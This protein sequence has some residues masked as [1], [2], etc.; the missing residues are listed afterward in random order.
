MSA[1]HP[2]LASF[3]PTLARWFAERL[4]A[5]SDPQ[6]QGWPAI[7]RGEHT[8]IAAPTGTGKTLAAFLS[9][10][11]RLLTSGQALED[12]CTLLY[13]SPLKAL[14][15]DVQKNLSGPL[16][17]LRELDPSLPEVRVFVRSGDTPAAEREKM[18]RRPPHVVVTTPESFY[19]LLTSA[20]GRRVL[21]T[22]ETVIIDEIHAI[23]GDKRGAHLA[24][25][26]ER[27]DRLCGREVQRIGLSATQKPVRDVA[28]FLVGPDRRCTTVDIGHLR[29]MDLAIEIPESPLEA[30]C[31]HDTFDEIY[32]RLV[33]LIQAERTTL[34]FVGTRKMAER[35]SSRLAERLGKELVTCHHSSLSKER[36][37]DAETRLKA[38]QLRA[39]VTT[40]SLELGID[41]GDVDLVCQI[42]ASRSIATLLQRVGR[43]GHGIGRVPKGRIFPLTQ[44][45][46]VEA[47]ALLVAVNRRELD[48]TPRPDAPLDALAQQIVAECVGE[49][50]D[51]AAKQKLAQPKSKASLATNTDVTQAAVDADA[52]DPSAA[53][54][55][56]PDRIK[57]DD[58]F[59]MVRRAWP[60]RDLIRADFD[61]VWALH[62]E[63][64]REALLH[65]DRTTASLRATRR[66]PITAVTCGGA[67][68]D[69]ANYAVQLEPEGTRIG[70]LEEDFVIESSVGDIFQLGNASWQ[71]LRVRQGIVHVVD[72]QGAPPSLPFW[73]G[74]GPS[75]TRE[76]SE[77]IGE[78]RDRGTE[79]R[80][81]ESETGMS[82]VVARELREYLVQGESELGCMP[83]SD[84]LVLERFFDDTGGTQVVLHAPLG[85]RMNRGLGLA[86]RKCFCRSFG[87]ELQAAATEEAI[88]LSLGLMHSFPLKDVWS[89]LHSST[90][91]EVL[92]QALLDSPMF[93]ARWRWSLSR[94]LLLERMRGGKRVPP[95][96]LR[97]RADDFLAEAFPE[98]LA[99][100]ENL[101]P[102]DLPIPMGHP[103]VRESVQDCL[104]SAMDIEGLE[105]LLTRIESGAIE[106]VEIERPEPSIFA[107]G[108][109]NAGPYAFLDDAP[110]EERRTQAV[111]TGR[112]A[113]SK[114]ADEIHELDPDAVAL[115][116]SEAWP[117]PRDAEELHEALTWMG[118]LGCD[119]LKRL[120]EGADA[121][122]TTL[123]AEG[124]IVREG[125]AWFATEAS[126]DPEAVLAAR[127]SVLGPVVTEQIDIFTLEG[128]GLVCRVRFE[129]CEQW[130]DRRLLARIQRA[131][132]ER[133]RAEIKPVKAADFLN[134]L[135][136]RHYVEPST[137]RDG[138]QGLL[139]CTRRLAG[140]ELPAI[141]LERS[142]LAARFQDYRP[143]WLDQASMSGQVSWLRLWGSS[144]CAIR[145]APIALVSRSEQREWAKLA[146]PVEIESMSSSARKLF[147]AMDGGGALFLEDLERKSRLLPSQLEE[148]LIELVTRGLATADSY[149]SL[150]WLL[151][152]SNKRRQPLFGAGRW[153]LSAR[154]E[155]SREAEPDSGYDESA[156]GF[157]AEKLLA[158]YGVLFRRMLERE[159]IPVPW[160]DLARCLRGMELRGEVRGGRFVAG[161]SG[162]QFA[163]SGAVEALRA[164]RRRGPS[165]PWQVHAAD[166]LNLIGILTPADRLSSTSKEMATFDV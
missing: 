35:F 154:A 94:A 81:L 31:S 62:A 98:A 156:L 45:E 30:V 7:E 110:L 46:L 65:H 139:D 56:R 164:A 51:W 91:R 103:M 114:P 109:L 11:N 119:E 148:G 161:F 8:L 96:I 37:L 49:R 85:A 64:G 61:S 144:A 21:K 141:E 44:D 163:A 42:G 28:D 73:F 155:M 143:E 75:R 4:G 130:C 13:V 23:L 150:R 34:V 29:E 107:R 158:R 92:S 52:N 132:L 159:R 133:L 134:F 3:H 99:C 113:S 2:G 106:L 50:V 53:D 16:A 112:R 77:L 116:R 152:P 54:S 14:A 145:R 87:F 166:P 68:P 135:R 40:A 121:W 138:P 160:R 84:R 9:G 70:T 17:E 126:H 147:D 10:L 165:G 26:L 36:R 149:T 60:Y 72:A 78:L 83:T 79:P 97:M 89:F 157:L 142:V 5:P 102:G 124:R 76:L 63:R 100:G 101:A 111:L 74:E 47:G 129:G 140:F 80:W 117:D 67:I 162:E 59:A 105:G 19:I 18:K 104:N 122:V 66:A 90:V 20:G 43:A 58:L 82:P 33:T 108:V 151:V 1:P 136:R 95:P 24:L 93:T 39:L 118:Y 131:T 120:P 86:L 88:V 137:R 57:C 25:S 153:N 6:L 128:R 38:G 48:R 27:L 125:Q 41:I 115:V 146:A 69:N 12:R 32:D 123:Q 127:L 22:V 55:T 71:V 15:R